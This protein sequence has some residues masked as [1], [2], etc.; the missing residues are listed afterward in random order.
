M[1]SQAYIF[2]ALGKAAFKEDEKWF[3]LDNNDSNNVRAWHSFD[4]NWLSLSDPEA[5]SVPEGKNL[6]DLRQLLALE[7]SKQEA[8]TLA[9]QLMDTSIR[10]KPLKKEIATL[11]SE[12][13]QNP[14]IF[15]FLENRL[16]TTIVPDSF[17]PSFASK[18]C[19]SLQLKKIAEVYEMLDTHAG[20]IQ[21]FYTAWVKVAK[22]HFHDA[23]KADSAFSL[24]TNSGIARAFV[25][26]IAKRDERLLNKVALDA[27]LLFQKEEEAFNDLFFIEL[28][29]DFNLLFRET[30]SQGQ[31][32]TAK[33]DITQT[34]G[35][36]IERCRQGQRDAQFQL[37]KLYSKTMYNTALRM[38]KNPQEAEDLVQSVFA[39]VFTT[40]D[41][42]RY[43]SSVGAW[44]K[45][46]T[47]NECISFLKSRRDNNL[48]VNAIQEEEELKGK[49]SLQKA[50]MEYLSI[51]TLWNEPIQS[52]MTKDVVTIKPDS[53]INEAREIMIK[54]HIHHLPVLEGKK[55][56]GIITS[57]DM[58]KLGISAEEFKSMKAR[59]VMTTKVATL[60]PH[61][62]LGAVADVLIRGLFHAVPIVND[63]QELIGIVTST[64]I[65]RYRHTKEYSENME[66]LVREYFL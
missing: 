3:V 49:G 26:S 34:H 11:L 20:Q 22:N 63:K 42:F 8:L 61:H 19:R 57:W 44:I 30:V 60:E 13:T 59:D 18:V 47:V 25:E 31:E 62:H 23:E 36:L 39:K 40:I 41:T 12:Y 48:V 4:N 51:T 55:L 29:D 5:V 33:T 1:I 24:L 2:G 21:A 64:D 7:T 35:D 50:K 38:V 43:Q 27:A 16:L 14:E 10:E 56:V 37:Y 6:D 53:T 66:N 46:I 28:K 9:L 32:K 17:D 15:Q 52:Y 45:R 58:F 54:K 65:I